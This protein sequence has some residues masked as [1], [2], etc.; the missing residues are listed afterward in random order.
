MFDSPGVTIL[1]GLTPLA[2]PCSPSHNISMLESRMSHVYVVRCSFIH[3]QVDEEEIP[4][5]PSTP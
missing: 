1:T 2:P 5:R 3:G 4:K